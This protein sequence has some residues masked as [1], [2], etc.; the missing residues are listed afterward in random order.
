MMVVELFP[1][2]LRLWFGTGIEFYWLISYGT[3]C[4]L[5]YAVR[6]WRVLQLLFSVPLCI[7]IGLIW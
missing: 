3:T 1:P 6:D 7:S 2:E 4:I 5:I